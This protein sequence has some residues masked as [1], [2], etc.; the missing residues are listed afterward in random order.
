MID[1]FTEFGEILLFFVV[2]DLGEIVGKVGSFGGGFGGF[3][4][5]RLLLL[6]QGQFQL[7]RLHSLFHMYLTYPIL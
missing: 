3:V 7:L 6:N 2:M 1:E 5:V 4:G